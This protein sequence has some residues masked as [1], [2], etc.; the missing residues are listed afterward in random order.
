MYGVVHVYNNIENSSDSIKIRLY[1]PVK[2]Y[3][4]PEW[5]ITSSYEEFILFYGEDELAKF[6][7]DRNYELLCNR[8][9]RVLGSANCTK[10]SDGSFLQDTGR[11]LHTE[12]VYDIPESTYT[13]LVKFNPNAKDFNNFYIY[14]RKY[15]KDLSALSSDSTVMYSIGLFGEDY[16]TSLGTGDWNLGKSKLQDQFH[17]TPTTYSVFMPNFIFEKGQ[18]KPVTYT[19]DDIE[20]AIVNFFKVN[21][22]LDVIELG[23]HHYVI[24]VNT[25][26]FQ[27]H[28]SN[29][30]VL[31][32]VSTSD[33]YYNKVMATK[34][35]DKRVISISSKY[36]SGYS[37]ISVTIS[38]GNYDMYR[39]QVRK[40]DTTTVSEE[41]FE[42]TESNIEAINS[43][44]IEVH[45]LDRTGDITG[46][47][48]LKGDLAYYEDSYALNYM[49][50]FDIEEYDIPQTDIVIDLTETDEILPYYRKNFPNALILSNNIK[51]MSNLIS[52]SPK[53]IKWTDTDVELQSYFILLELL[54]EYVSLF[55]KQVMEPIE[56]DSDLMFKLGETDYEYIL[57]DL[58]VTVRGLRYSFK[59]AVAR[60]ILYRSLSEIKSRTKSEIAEEINDLVNKINEY[61]SVIISCD[62]VSES[63]SGTK[64]T[65]VLNIKL[66][67]KIFEKYIL[68]I[69]VNYK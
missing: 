8:V 15:I 9:S 55:S 32:I 53:F 40:T 69:E 33:D 61:L 5:M 56:D 66:E 57:T 59:A 62:I 18:A 68:N 3:S 1:Y 6:L 60:A 64:Y 17:L 19:I 48:N 41:Y 51:S 12:L 38:E 20:D 44:I 16:I 26:D 2:S 24:S 34:M 11:Y 39:V 36:P 10:Y 14:V 52:I 63:Q 7:F 67:N 29:E 22:A 37:N 30:D 43:N 50:T 58:A 25:P 31:S 13:Y 65:L 27:L 4:G 46:T 28:C 21:C 35:Y 47:Y 49:K 45:L 54:P 23:D 42:V